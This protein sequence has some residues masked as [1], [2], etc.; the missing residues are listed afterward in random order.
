MRNQNFHR[1]LGGNEGTP[2]HPVPPV[3]TGGHKGPRTPTCKGS[4]S[5]DSALLTPPRS[6]EEADHSYI[7]GETVKWYNHYGQEFEFLQQ[8]NTLLPYNEA[9]AFLLIE[10]TEVRTYVHAKIRM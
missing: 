9:I 10:P 3:V 1:C 4:I 8:L 6:K 2:P 7:A 5:R